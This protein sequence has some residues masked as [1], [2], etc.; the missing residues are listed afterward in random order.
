MT[1]K[2]IATS[3]SQKK[4]TN[5]T[6]Q[7]FIELNENGVLGDAHAGSWH[8]LVSLLKTLPPKAFPYT[9][10]IPSIV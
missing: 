2:V 8:N 7:S 6:V 10:C 9:K 3:L 1:I 4:G 5:K